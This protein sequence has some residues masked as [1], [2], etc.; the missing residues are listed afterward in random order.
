MSWNPP[1]GNKER[2]A[3]YNKCGQKCFLLP[4]Q[5]CKG[6]ASS[7]NIYRYPICPKNSCTPTKTGLVAAE[8]RSTLV[9]GKMKI[10]HAPYS[11][12]APHARA[13]VRSKRLLHKA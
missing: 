2:A 3:M 7:C 5:S 8:R 1:K 4:P 6:K 10:H 9:L 11:S 13:L 12:K